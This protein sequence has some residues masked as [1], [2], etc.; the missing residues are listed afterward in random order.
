[1]QVG[2]VR[3]LLKR[4]DGSLSNPAIRSSKHPLP[5]FLSIV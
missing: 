3:V 1:M 4:E 2:R 5:S